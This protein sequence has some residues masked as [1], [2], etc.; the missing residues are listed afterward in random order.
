MEKMMAIRCSIFA[1]RR[2]EILASCAA[3]VACSCNATGPA[4]NTESPLSANQAREEVAAPPVQSAEIAAP[5]KKAVDPKVLAKVKALSERLRDE[6]PAL[7]G[8]SQAH[9]YTL[10]PDGEITGEFEPKVNYGNKKH[11][12][13]SND[14]TSF[15]NWSGRS[16]FAK[17]GTNPASLTSQSAGISLQESLP[18]PQGACGNTTCPDPLVNQTVKWVDP[19]GHVI[20]AF[21]NRGNN[22]WSSDDLTIATS[23]PGSPTPTAKGPLVA[24]QTTNNLQQHVI[25]ISSTDS[26]VHELFFDGTHWH[27]SDLTVLAGAKPLAANARALTGYQTT[28]NQEHVDYVDGDGDIIELRFVNPNWV[29]LNVTQNAHLLDSTTQQAQLASALTGYL[30]TFNGQQHIDYIGAN[31]DLCELFLG[32]DGSWHP[33]D[34]TTAAQKLNAN[35]PKPQPGSAIAA[36]VTTFGGFNQQHVDFIGQGNA[37]TTGDIWELMFDT[38]WHPNDL[39][40]LA[41]PFPSL[42]PPGAPVPNPLSALAG[43]ATTYNG[44]Q[45][46]DYIDKIGHVLELFFSG[47]QWIWNDLTNSASATLPV[48]TVAGT[49]ALDGFQITSP[50]IVTPSQQHVSF[51]SSNDSH[52]HDMFLN[53]GGG[54][55]WTDTDLTATAHIPWTTAVGTWQ[56]PT[57][58]EPIQ[59][60]SAVPFS[61]ASLTNGWDSTTWV[62]IDGDQGSTT[63]TPDVLQAGTQQALLD[64]DLTNPKYSAW[65]EWFTPDKDLTDLVIDFP[66]ISMSTIDNLPA[67]PGDVFTCT[68]SHAGS[69]GFIALTNVTRGL[70]FTT[71]LAPPPQANF[72]GGSAE[73][74]NETPTVNHFIGDN[75]LATLPD[76][77]PITFTSATATDANGVTANANDPNGRTIELD[78]TDFFSDDRNLTKTTVGATQ[79]EIDRVDWYENDLSRNAAAT[80]VPA[81][82]RV[83]GFEAPFNHQQH[84]MFIGRDDRHIHELVFPINN[85]WAHNDLTQQFGAMVVAVGS[86]L[87]GYVTTYDSQ[88]HVD[89]VSQDGHIRELWFDTTWHTHDLWDDA[90]QVDPSTP[91]AVPTSALNGYQTTFNNEQH[92]DYISATD[93]HVRE[94]WYD[95]SINTLWQPHDPWAEAHAASAA[96]PLPIANTA[97]AGYQTTWNSQQH[98][99]FISGSAGNFQLN[100]L[101][102]DNAWHWNGLTGAASRTGL[103]APTPAQASAIGSFPSPSNQQQHVN[104][105]TAGGQIIEYVFNNPNWSFNNL[106]IRGGIQAV[107]ASPR[108]LG[109]YQQVSNNQVANNQLRVD[110]I[111]TD[112]HARELR[113]DGTNWS[114]RDLT[115][116]SNG[117]N[118]WQVSVNTLAASRLASWETGLDI[119]VI[120]IVNEQHHVAYVGTDNRV[121]ELL[122]GP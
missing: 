32:A 73:W 42:S 24:F 5:A 51:V 53:S 80:A 66:Y 18:L 112:N 91:L 22:G 94:L 83:V 27:H 84:I 61:V 79:V 59:S 45:H 111:S 38:Q 39:T 65:F 110:F 107:V 120:G 14:P 44:Q 11:P 62:G 57:I 23:T 98:I 40:T 77:T 97:L 109:G 30:T 104:F 121:H 119:P 55:T 82:G 9:G 70:M 48:G 60:S 96:T 26:D 102:Y 43:Y 1:R 50:N 19:N 3:L 101:W 63:S 117:P 95:H 103:P 20:E 68:L 100:E 90:H 78:R 69:T 36:Y 4:D 46:V 85:K 35:T 106:S 6:A 86:N 10:S 118:D 89:Y 34:L 17:I 41:L 28:D 13:A 64:D 2:Y 76:F 93:G 15:Q 52:V 56:V 116:V 33:N 49:A 81:N 92:V 108:T 72:E 21:F 58:S 87:T 122:H 105:V 25:Y 99:N 114:G 12:G 75:E 29:A 113:F 67:E 54:N 88:Q 74:I 37:T 115:I 31:G 7:S 71:Q 8:H 16:L 47:T